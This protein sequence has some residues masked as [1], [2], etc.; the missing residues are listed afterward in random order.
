MFQYFRLIS[1]GHQLSSATRSMR[2]IRFCGKVIF[3][4]YLGVFTC[5]TV[6]I[7]VLCASVKGSITFVDDPSISDSLF[8]TGS[9]HHISSFDA[10]VRTSQF[11]KFSSRDHRRI[12]DGNR[13][14]NV[15]AEDEDSPG[16]ADAILSSSIGERST[17]PRPES[18]ELSFD[19]IPVLDRIISYQRIL[20]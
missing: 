7:D 17:L 2:L 12:A 15:V 10:S 4:L 18:N 16:I 11:Q 8:D 1:D 3:L 14:K 5:D 9:V 20:I 19:A 6:N 13:V